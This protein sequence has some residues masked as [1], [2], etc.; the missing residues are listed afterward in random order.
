LVRVHVAN[1]EWVVDLGKRS[2]GRGVWVHPQLQCLRRACQGGLQ[3]ALVGTPGLSPRPPQVAE[4]IER[5]RQAGSERAIAL[6]T[7]ERALPEARSRVVW[8][9]PSALQALAEQRAEL[10]V[11]VADLQ[12]PEQA[13]LRPALS[14]GRARIWGDRAL[15]LRLSG[16]AGLATVGILDARLARALAHAV[17]C[18]QVPRLTPQDSLVRRSMEVR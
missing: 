11:A 8:G 17:D 6:L 13:A 16:R 3:R 10:L 12:V 2:Q 9:V 18:A 15:W 7:G 4:L 1:G 14:S 5:V